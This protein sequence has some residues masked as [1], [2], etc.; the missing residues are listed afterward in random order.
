MCV[1]VCAYFLIYFQM[2]PHEDTAVIPIFHTREPRFTE[3]KSLDK[4]TQL[5]N[6]ELEPQVVCSPEPEYSIPPG[7]QALKAS[8]SEEGGLWTGQPQPSAC[9]HGDGVPGHT[10]GAGICHGV[11]VQ[12][13]SWSFRASTRTP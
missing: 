5:I 4:V 3:V 11:F 10:V 6:C 1:C 8:T 2:V 7:L 9:L 13:R 12:V